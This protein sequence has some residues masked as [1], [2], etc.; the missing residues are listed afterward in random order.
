[1]ETLLVLTYTALCYGVFKLFKIKLTGY[2]VGTALLGGVAMLGLLMLVMNYNHPYTKVAQTAVATTPI[3]PDVRGHV[4][5]VPV[6]PNKFLK[7]GDVLFRIDPIPF[8]L[9]VQRLEALVSSALTQDEQLDAELVEAKAATAQAAA[10]LEAAKSELG[11]QVRETVDQANAVVE[12]VAS[13]LALAQIDLERDTE[14]L[15]RGVIP[16][17]RLDDT[18]QRVAGLEAELRQAEAQERQATEKLGSSGD[19]LLSVQE[20]YRR[21]EAQERAVQLAFDSESGGLNPVVRQRQAELEEKRWELSRTVV[22]APT[23]GL[24]TQLLLRPGMMAVPLP[25]A[26]SMLFIHAEKPRLVAM[27]QQNYLQRLEIGNKA[28]VIFPALPGEIFEGRIVDVLPVLASGALQTGGKLISVASGPPD[29]APVIIELDTDMPDINLPA[30]SVA[31]VAIITEHFHHV[32]I[33]RQIL[34]RMKSWQNY[35]FSEG[36]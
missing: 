3:I 24:V 4:V 22:R 15:A 35:I 33:I 1:M 16:R 26:P 12:R 2:T 28:E 25:L 23:D 27:F 14:L 11:Q 20:K 29:R 6:V 10:E 31:E 9:E 19:L 7:K 30:G 17:K 13:E 5:D 18:K 34:L 32:A 21:A 8:E 36:H